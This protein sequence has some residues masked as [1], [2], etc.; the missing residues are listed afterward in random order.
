MIR[1]F[2]FALQF[3]ILDGGPAVVKKLVPGKRFS[4]QNGLQVAE[5]ETKDV[6][7]MLARKPAQNVSA[8]TRNVL[9]TF[10]F[11]RIGYEKM[12]VV[13]VVEC[14]NQ[15]DTRLSTAWPGLARQQIFFGFAPG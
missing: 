9:R 14:I 15:P 12:G 10:N 4:D 5:A 2:Y 13:K 1:R 7:D 11:H 8:E 6:K 3:N